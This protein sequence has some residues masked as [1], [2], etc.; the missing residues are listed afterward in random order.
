MPAR[1]LG[2]AL[3]ASLALPA[4][5]DE[6]TV[7]AAASLKTALDAVAADWQAATGNREAPPWPSAPGPR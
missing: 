4:A 7:F 3:A 5:A 6:V 1:R 2:L